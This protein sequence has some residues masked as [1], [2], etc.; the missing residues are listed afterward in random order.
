MLD[1][2][3]W[4][5]E[6]GSAALLHSPSFPYA[7]EMIVPAGVLF[8]ASHVRLVVTAPLPPSKHCDLLLFL[9]I[10]SVTDRAVST[11]GK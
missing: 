4:K 5:G 3:G 9:I 1:N 8:L 7:M 11:A 10:T 2:A 6:P